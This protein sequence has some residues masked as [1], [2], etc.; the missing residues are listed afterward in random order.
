M[1]SE[2]V[3]GF[4]QPLQVPVLMEFIPLYRG[5]LAVICVLPSNT[6]NFLNLTMHAKF[7]GLF[8][9]SAGTEVQNLK[10]TWARVR[11]ISQF[12]RSHEFYHCQKTLDY[13]IF[14]S[15]RICFICCYNHA[16]LFIRWLK[17][18]WEDCFLLDLFKKKKNVILVYVYPYSYFDIF[19]NCNWVYTRRQ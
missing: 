1:F 14:Y 17:Y 6:T 4:I 9:P 2:V 3:C 10:T 15:L 8:R 5:R 16:P 18:F 7:F 12:L 19:V 13:F 11:S